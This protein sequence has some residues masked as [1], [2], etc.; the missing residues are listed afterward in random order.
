MYMDVKGRVLGASLAGSQ[1]G[2][3]WEQA[4]LVVKL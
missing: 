2:N 1:M 4:R 3:V